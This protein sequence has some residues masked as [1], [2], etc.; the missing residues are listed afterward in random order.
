MVNIRVYFRMLV[1]GTYKHLFFQSIK[2]RFVILTLQRYYYFLSLQIFSYFFSSIF[3]IFLLLLLQ[4]LKN[5]SFTKTLFYFNFQ[6]LI[7]L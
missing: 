4:A 1:T 6:T 2:E 3:F 7:L 5:Q